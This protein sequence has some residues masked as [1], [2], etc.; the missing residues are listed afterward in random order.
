MTFYRKISIIVTVLLLFAFRLADAATLFLTTD[1]Q[2]PSVGDTVSVN[3]RIG[4][5]QTVNAVQ[6]TLYYPRDIFDVKQVIRSS[7]IFDIWL[8]EP[9]VN[10]ST[11][12]ISFLGGSTNDYSGNSMQVLTVVFGTRGSG[13]GTMGFKD[14]VV[15]A[16]DG[17]GANILTSSTVMLFTA[18]ASGQT[19]PPPPPQ[20]QA[21]TTVTVPLPPIVQVPPP[22]PVQIVRP[23]A[24]AA[25]LPVMPS[26]VVALYPEQAKWYNT[27]GNF[28][29]QWQLPADVSAVAT[30]VNQNPNFEPTDSEGLFDNK[31]FGAIGENIWYLHVR[32]KNSIGWGPVSHY[33][34]AIDTTPPFDMAAKVNEGTVAGAPS[35][36]VQFSAQD[37]PSGVGFYNVLVDGNM[38]GS[39]TSTSFMLPSLSFGVHQIF[40]QA[41]DYAGNVIEKRL[42]VTIAEPPFLVI[43]GLKITAPIFFVTIIAVIVIG[44]LIGWWLG[45]KVTSRRHAF[46]T[47]AIR[48]VEQ[49]SSN[50]IDQLDEVKK[51][52]GS[53]ES[54]DSTLPMEAANL[55]D[56]ARITAEQIKKYIAQEIE[57]LK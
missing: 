24:P 55:T 36:T 50:L 8:R 39:T 52:V 45:R 54:V 43:A 49:L 47:I 38:A 15:A 30:A 10:S 13:N 28:L 51:R 37:Q 6:G 42:S 29:A 12:E 23:A 26:V 31:T 48:D 41:V 14:A 4:S 22:A 18:T 7:S 1:N 21:T 40:V 34:I 32:F 20:G 11:G 46:E 44:I 35:P 2:R 9:S 33:R 27:V 57:K 16:G 53:I 17:T 19:A 5:D 3:V 56:Q 25:K